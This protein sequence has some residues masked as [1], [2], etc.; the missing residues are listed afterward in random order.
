MPDAGLPPPAERWRDAPPRYEPGE[1]PEGF[2]A[3]PAGGYQ[4]YLPQTGQYQAQDYPG[5]QREY[6]DSDPA[7]DWSREDT[8]YQDFPPGPGFEPGYPPG[9]T[10]G[11]E[12]EPLD[13][14]DT[15][16]GFVDGGD[17]EYGE[18]GEYAE[19]AGLQEYPPGRPYV[20]APRASVEDEF[21]PSRRRGGRRDD[22]SAPAAARDRAGRPPRG[23]GPYPGGH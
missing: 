1:P 11:R 9:E 3:A 12:G 19:D 6:R 10:F 14:G 15:D 16:P 23:R 5:E 18:P 17:L 2:G 22:E 4:E 21:P 7:G 8:G 20:A 13:F